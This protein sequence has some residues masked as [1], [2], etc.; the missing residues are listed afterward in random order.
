MKLNIGIMLLTQF[1]LKWLFPKLQRSGMCEAHS[2][3]PGGA[4]LWVNCKYIR[5]TGGALGVSPL[6]AGPAGQTRGNLD[7]AEFSAHVDLPHD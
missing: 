5:S 1:F 3:G 7:I 2:V 6:C 4:K